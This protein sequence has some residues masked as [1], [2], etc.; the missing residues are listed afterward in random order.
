MPAG[1]S[2]TRPFSP[3]MSSALDPPSSSK[4]SKGPLSGLQ[5]NNTARRGSICTSSILPLPVSAGLLRLTARY[6]NRARASNLFPAGYIGCCFK[7]VSPSISR[8]SQCPLWAKKRTFR[9]RLLAL[10][11]LRDS[12][13]Q[14]LFLRLPPLPREVNATLQLLPFSFKLLHLLFVRRCC[15]L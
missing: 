12:R 14:L 4:T 7:T 8:H 9:P 3:P 10:P 11:G 1:D 15:L 5:G 2:L 6:A 13:L